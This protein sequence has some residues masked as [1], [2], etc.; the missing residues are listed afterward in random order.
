MASAP[1]PPLAEMEPA[2]DRVPTVSQMLPP[3]PPPPPEPEPLPPLAEMLPFTCNVPLT[4]EPDCATPG[5]ADGIR[6]IISAAAARA[7]GR[8]DGII[9][10]FP[11]QKRNFRRC[12]RR[13]LR[14]PLHCTDKWTG[15]WSCSCPAPDPWPAAITS[16]PQGCHRPLNGRTRQ[17][18]RV[19]IVAD[20]QPGV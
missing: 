4:R 19:G 10:V 2:P 3:E 14:D 16:D 6:G 17:S 1:L 18:H 13:S 20:Q 8:C 7:G 9:N 15:Y 11:G 12:L 5:A